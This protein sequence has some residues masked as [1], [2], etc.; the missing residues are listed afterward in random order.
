VLAKAESCL[1]PKV[2]QRAEQILASFQTAGDGH[3]VKVQ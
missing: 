2:R 3:E 1:L